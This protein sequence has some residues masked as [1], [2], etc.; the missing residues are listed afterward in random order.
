MAAIDR[1]PRQSL[2]PYHGLV[3]AFDLS[4]GDTL[5]LQPALRSPQAEGRVSFGWGVEPANG[6][7]VTVS[8]RMAPPP[9]DFIAPAVGAEIRESYLSYEDAPLYA[10]RWQAVGGTGTTRISVA[11]RWPL[12]RA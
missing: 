1:S 3:Y 10:V 9:A 8:Y 4:D 12:E 6:A 7:V 2:P 11:S 5:I